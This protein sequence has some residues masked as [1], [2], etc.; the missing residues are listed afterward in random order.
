[1]SYV[2]QDTKPVPNH[3]PIWNHEYDNRIDNVKADRGDWKI[4]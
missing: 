3:N 1:V 2:E 4:S